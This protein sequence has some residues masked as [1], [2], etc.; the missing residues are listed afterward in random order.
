M[1]SFSHRLFRLAGL[2]GGVYATK[3]MAA[4]TRH[5]KSALSRYA[6]RV[7]FD[8]KA[9]NPE[10]LSAAL[11]SF[12]E[13]DLASSLSE[14]PLEFWEA[15]HRLVQRNAH[16]LS[17]EMI[18]VLAPD[19]EEGV[20]ERVVEELYRF[21]TI[22][23]R[24]G[25]RG[26]SGVKVWS[27]PERVARTKLGQIATVMSRLPPL[28]KEYIQN[29]ITWSVTFHADPDENEAIVKAAFR[30]K[31]P[32][33]FGIALS[34]EQSLEV[35]NSEDVRSTE[36]LFRPE[37]LSIHLYPRAYAGTISHEIGHAV[38]DRALTPRILKK[39]LGDYLDRKVMKATIRDTRN[40]WIVEDVESFFQNLKR[41]LHGLRQR[42]TRA[43]INEMKA[44]WGKNYAD[45]T[46]GTAMVREIGNLY[47]SY[48]DKK[49]CI[50]AVVEDN[51]HLFTA[52]NEAWAEGFSE[53]LLFIVPALEVPGVMLSLIR[54]I[55]AMGQLP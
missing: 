12:P 27:E 40:E 8:P 19:R 25:L 30:A 53:T 1:G 21:L 45:E 15:L 29:H 9:L 35:H 51:K 41:A 39:F 16:E 5:P 46:K 55:L 48:D 26:D 42:E 11:E 34:R 44:E 33:K 24:E 31:I 6:Y 17:P 32:E 7:L 36:G 43:W 47:M 50:D 14:W 38:W 54:E 3:V 4:L 28:W 22:M 49:R 18:D 23:E 52:W 20:S 10:A 13:R 37:D 2:F